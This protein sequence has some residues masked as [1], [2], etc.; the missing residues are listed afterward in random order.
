MIFFIDL[1]LFLFAIYHLLAGMACLGPKSWM[2]KFSKQTYSLSVPNQYEP[3]YDI[4][5]KFLGLLSLT[6]SAHLF[7][8]YFLSEL[9]LKKW[10]TLIWG[11]TLIL[12]SMLRLF[13]RK[14]FFDAY[15][16]IFSRSLLNITLNIF[17]GIVCVVLFILTVK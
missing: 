12:R 8:I 5:V 7:C 14:Q 1:L 6:L 3:R 16:L 9:S 15:G 4:T 11:I 17:L 10:C 2:Q 13:L